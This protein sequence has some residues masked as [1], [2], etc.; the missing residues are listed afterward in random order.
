MIVLCIDFR[1]SGKFLKTV[2]HSPVLLTRKWFPLIK[3]AQYISTEIYNFLLII[4]DTKHLILIKLWL[5]CTRSDMVQEICSPLSF[6]CFSSGLSHD[7][8]L[9]FFHLSV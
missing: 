5:S 9:Y 2:N 8:F 4:S 7:R 3:V 1:K 6:A